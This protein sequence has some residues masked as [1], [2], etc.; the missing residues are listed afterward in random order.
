MNGDRNGNANSM[1]DCYWHGS[2]SIIQLLM[3][4]DSLLLLQVMPLS[5]VSLGKGT[6]IADLKQYMFSIACFF[7]SITVSLSEKGRTQVGLSSLSGS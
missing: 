4:D 6:A 2:K 5:S 3:D 1:C 7:M